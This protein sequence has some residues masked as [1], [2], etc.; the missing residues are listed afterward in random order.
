MKTFLML[1]G[2]NISVSLFVLQYQDPPNPVGLMCLLL[3]CDLTV[4]MGLHY[5][6]RNKVP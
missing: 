3:A 1:T 4:L 5:F 6:M 2:L